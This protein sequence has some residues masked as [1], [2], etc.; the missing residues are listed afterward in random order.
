MS[1][2]RPLAPAAVACPACG[3]GLAPEAI[4]RVSEVACPQ[5]R[6]L[7][8]GDFFPVFWSPPATGS[9]MADRADDGEAVCFF[10]PE[11]RATLSCDRCGRFVCTVCDMPLGTRHLCPTCLSSGLGAEKLPELIVRRFHWANAAFLAGLL[12][13]F[14]FFLWPFFIVTGPLAIFCALFGWKRPGSVPRGRR[15][16][17][18]VLGLLLGIV[19]LAVLVGFIGLF[20]SVFSKES[21]LP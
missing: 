1:L 5:C 4:G 6:T 14:A 21:N 10:H 7:L 20:A 9:G 15:H 3:Y 18:A 17:V 16:W 2:A 8:C 19:Q 13:L 12:P 11:N